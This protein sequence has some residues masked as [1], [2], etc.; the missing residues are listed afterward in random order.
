MKNWNSFIVNA[1][2]TKT[3][4]L[5]HN[6]ILLRLYLLLE[7]YISMVDIRCI[8]NQNRG[9]TTYHRG[10]VNKKGI[11]K[12]SK[13]LFEYIQSKALSSPNSI[14]TIDFLH[15]TKAFLILN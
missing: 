3:S 10:S 12:Y 5:T 11:L 2:L 15:L 6:V 9:L 7:N 14:K 4:V 13:D 8:S 1:Y